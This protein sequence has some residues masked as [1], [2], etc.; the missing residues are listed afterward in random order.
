MFSN[1]NAQEIL[2]TTIVEEIPTPQIVQ[3]I[4]LSTSGTSR[5]GIASYMN[6][7]TKE[8]FINEVLKRTTKSW[9]TWRYGMPGSYVC[10]LKDMDLKEFEQYFD[11][12]AEPRICP[13]SEKLVT[14]LFRKEISL[15]YGEHKRISKIPLLK[16]SQLKIGGIYKQNSDD[17]W[18][19]LY[20]GKVEKCKTQY[21][22]RTYKN[23]SQYV[24]GIGFTSV[25]LREG[26]IQE[27]GLDEN[28][29]CTYILA[30]MKKLVEDTGLTY[31]PLKSEYTYNYV[32][33][34]RRNGGMYSWLGEDDY[35]ITTKLLE[36]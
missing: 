29:A 16:K 7:F 19:Y 36:V 30:G 32:N 26:K 21:N 28:I 22:N 10:L 11:V 1:T 25:N 17:S 23:E 8:Q 12:C 2:N 15:I 4:F 6:M 14:Q 9:G 3:P 35:T 18:G 5:G 13:F 27:S 24:R 34:N 20:L 31:L 33:H